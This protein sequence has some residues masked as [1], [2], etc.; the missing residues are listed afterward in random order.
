MYRESY[1]AVQ[2]YGYR[3]YVGQVKRTTIKAAMGA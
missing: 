2:E 3:R 1:K